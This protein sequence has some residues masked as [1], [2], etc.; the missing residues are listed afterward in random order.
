MAGVEK[1]CQT[2]L[3][4]QPSRHISTRFYEDYASVAAAVEGGWV[5]CCALSALRT[6]GLHAH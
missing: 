5:D 3:L 6:P 1:P 2:L 4:I